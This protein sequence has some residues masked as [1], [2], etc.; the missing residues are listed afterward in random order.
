MRFDS[1]KELKGEAFRRLTGIQR[2]AFEEM[3]ALFA[4]K[5]KQKAA[6][7]HRH[8]QTLQDRRRPLQEPPT[9]LR[10]ALLP[11]R[12]HLQQGARSNMT[13]MQEVKS[14]WHCVCGGDRRSF[15]LVMGS[16][17]CLLFFA[18]M[19]LLSIVSVLAIPAEAID[20]ERARGLRDG[21]AEPRDTSSRLAVLMR[22]RGLL[23]F[24]ICCVLFYLADAA[25]L[26]LRDGA[27][28][29]GLR[30]DPGAKP[31]AF[32]LATQTRQAP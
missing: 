21:P 22:N 18:G 12:R 32:I 15:R 23:I 6:G 17:R 26:P 9:P 27:D 13:V 29:R 2:D 20:H 19:A 31:E 30:S 11:H 28:P 8:A 7:G 10:P 4:A 5:C 16:S 25:M 24:C 14:C 1:V 3:A